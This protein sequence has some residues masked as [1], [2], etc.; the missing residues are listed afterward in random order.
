VARFDELSVLDT[1]LVPGRGKVHARAHLRD[2]E[3]TRHQAVEE[4]SWLHDDDYYGRAPS[5]SNMCG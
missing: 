5:L 4:P 2:D 1:D 3:R